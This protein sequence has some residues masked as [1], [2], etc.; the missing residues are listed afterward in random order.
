MI[1]TTEQLAKATY[2]RFLPNGGVSVDVRGF[3]ASPDGQRL[4]ASFRGIKAKR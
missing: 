3:L 1:L 4:L 2:A